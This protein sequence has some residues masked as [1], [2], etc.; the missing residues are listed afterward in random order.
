MQI[1]D[2]REARTI[3]RKLM[4]RNF[5]AKIKL[6]LGKPTGQTV[7]LLD[8]GMV[9]DA[10]GYPWFY[11]QKGTLKAYL[12]SLA[13]GYEGSINI[14]HQSFATFPFLVGSWTKEDLHLVDIGD[15][16]CGLDVDLRLDPDNMF[17]KM[18]HDAPYD[19]GVSAEFTYSVNYEASEELGI[20]VY[21]SIFIKDFAIVGDA[22]NV[23][24]S[25]I[26][27]EGGGKP[28][29]NIKELSNLIDKELAKKKVDLKA[30]AEALEDEKEEK[31]DA[32]ASEDTSESEAEA[33]ESN[34]EE[35][36]EESSAEDEKTAEEGSEGEDEDSD[37]E[38]S[39]EE[40]SL[41]TI[42]D[43]VNK[44]TAEVE[45]LKAS[46]DTLAEE[47]KTLTGK[48]NAKE[49]EEEEFAKKFK[50]LSVRL[51][52]KPSKKHVESVGFT[53]GIGEL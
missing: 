18:L 42:L 52:D 48:L 24:S 14:G 16:R 1:I 31:L 35:E 44:L 51:S 27:L 5:D 20:E 10:N 21:D 12:D 49:A 17:V 33:T 29:K 43:A 36:V 11:I 9:V 50:T 25:G 8:E 2:D 22:G 7:R 53:D 39:K 30:L 34:S 47:N 26:K 28:M 13:D 32:D 23:N 45:T 46:N 19:V 4:K 15:G 37:E 6:A 41:Q 38:D 3:Y 40:L